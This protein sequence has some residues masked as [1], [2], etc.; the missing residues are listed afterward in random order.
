MVLPEFCC[1][2]SSSNVERRA[3]ESLSEDSDK[4]SMVFRINRNKE[5]GDCHRRDYHD[6]FFVA[7]VAK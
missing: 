3:E 6:L 7:E 4:L 1:Q 5:F 2:R